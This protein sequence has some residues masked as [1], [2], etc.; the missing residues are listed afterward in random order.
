MNHRIATAL[1]STV[2]AAVLVVPVWT[3]AQQ[4]P[5]NAPGQWPCGARLDSSYFQLAEGTGGQLFLLAPEEIADSAPLLTAFGD[6]RQTILRSAGAINPGV[7]EFRV[8][9][10]PSVESVLFSISVQCLRT[11]EITRPSGAALTD[12]DGVTKLSNFQAQR[13]FIVQKP[14]TGVWTLRVGG[15]GVGGVMVQ[16]RSALSIASVEFASTGS[17][18]FSVAPA[19]GVENIVRL[20]ITGAP[21]EWEASLVDASSRQVMMLTLSAGETPGSYLS[22]FTPGTE[23]FRVRIA[24]KDGNGVP[25][26]RVHAPLVTAVVCMTDDAAALASR[27]RHPVSVSTLL[28]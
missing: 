14:E 11:A 3:G 26:Q 22:R 12:G 23:G 10:D 20:A 16:A 17:T 15:S 1:G 19:L 24:G 8:P 7:H 6:H 4:Q 27:S 2:T 13:M 9:I 18:A 21:I 5:S 28:R 25:F